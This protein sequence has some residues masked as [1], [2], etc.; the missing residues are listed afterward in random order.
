VPS[1]ANC[2]NRVFFFGLEL[3][4]RLLGGTPPCSC[5]QAQQMAMA[6]MEA[7]SEAAVQAGKA[8]DDIAA[9][10][11][12]VAAWMDA[13]TGRHPDWSAGTTSLLS[14]LFGIEESGTAFL[15]RLQGL[16]TVSEEMR[17]M[18]CL[19]L[20]LDSN[21]CDG[22]GQEP[23]PAG[24]PTASVPAD[25][26]PCPLLTPAT[27]TTQ[28]LTPQPYL[29]ADPGPSHLPR[30]WDRLI[31]RSAVVPAV[32]GPL[33]V[34]I[35]GYRH[36]GVQPPATLALVVPAPA[37]R[38]VALDRTALNDVRLHYRCARIEY[39]ADDGAGHVYGTT[40]RRREF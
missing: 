5:E 19:A 2:F 17:A 20:Y 40:S 1:L 36:P 26:P 31:W 13:L 38:T 4:E 3:E 7:A 14:R 37:D 21:G 23:A 29:S 8:P 39:V 18:Y 27:F 16:D 12:V 6:H 11:R 35:D 10:C 34:L 33:A 25:P 28:Y 24:A 32:L 30:H 22:N 9:A 15:A